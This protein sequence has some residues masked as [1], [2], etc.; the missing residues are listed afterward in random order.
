MKIKNQR[1]V[2]VCTSFKRV[3]ASYAMLFLTAVSLSVQ[4]EY[5]DAFK[6]HKKAQK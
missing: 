2:I 6:S 5:I 3:L 4:T 1:I